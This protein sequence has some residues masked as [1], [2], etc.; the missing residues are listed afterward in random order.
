[1][2]RKICAVLSAG[3]C[4]LLAG[5]T[6]SSGPEDTAGAFWQAMENGDLQ[7]AAGFVSE[8]A[9]EYMQSLSGSMDSLVETAESYDLSEETA[10]KNQNIY[11]QYHENHIR[12]PYGTGLRRDI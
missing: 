7:K 5:C 8:E 4:L 12:R 9:E 11:I 1:M 3:L 10:G 2:M 6:G